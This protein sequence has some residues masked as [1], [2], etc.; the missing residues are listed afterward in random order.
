MDGAGGGALGLAEGVAE[1]LVDPTVTGAVAGGGFVASVGVDATGWGAPGCSG[2]RPIVALAGADAAGAVAGFT[3]LLVTAAGRGAGAATFTGGGGGAGAALTG[4]ALLGVS[5][6]LLI[7]RRSCTDHFKPI[8]FSFSMYSTLSL[9]LPYAERCR[10]IHRP[11][12]RGGES[13]V[14]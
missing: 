9:S 11:S 13:S 8:E 1:A 10:L 12:A 5:G 2:G 14:R 4:V 6:V 7:G 3:V